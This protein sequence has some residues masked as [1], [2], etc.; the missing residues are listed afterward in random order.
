MA[1]LDTVALRTLRELTIRPG[2]VAAEYVDGR[3]ARYVS[4]LRYVLI[5]GGVLLSVLALTK[6]ANLGAP[7]MKTSIQFNNTLA[8]P[9]LA[10]PAWAVFAGSGRSYTG[11]L[12]LQLYLRGHSLL[13]FSLL[14][15]VA[16]L[17][18]ARPD[19]PLLYAGVGVGLLWQSAGL[20]QFHRDRVG[21][22]LPRVI[23]G[24]L[25]TELASGGV[26][27]ATALMAGRAAS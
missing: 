25:L 9:V 7:A 19:G 26:L 13:L 14:W 27:A 6:A 5:S 1:D 10:L 2:T 18:G 17:T 12:V 21:G 24:L 15:V 23:V 16:W 4:P 3:R 22:L 8:A 11:Q 20:W